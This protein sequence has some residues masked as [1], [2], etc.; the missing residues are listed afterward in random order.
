[1][2]EVLNKDA[3]K[4]EILRHLSVAKRGYISKGY[5]SEVIQPKSAVNGRLLLRFHYAVSV[6]RGGM[7]CNRSRWPS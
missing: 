6:S 2:C 3:L 5:L 7:P 1:M 4:N